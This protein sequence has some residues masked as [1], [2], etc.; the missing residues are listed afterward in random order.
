VKFPARKLSYKLRFEI[1][2]SYSYF[3]SLVAAG[4]TDLKE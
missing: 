3:A 2:E 4:R 1:N